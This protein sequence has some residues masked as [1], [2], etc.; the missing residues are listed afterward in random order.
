MHTFTP[1]LFDVTSTSGMGNEYK[2]VK[3]Y[4]LLVMLLAEPFTQNE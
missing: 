1:V 2:T 4:K 3:S